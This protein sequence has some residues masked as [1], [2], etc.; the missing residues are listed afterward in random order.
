MPPFGLPID[1]P[2]PGLPPIPGMPGMVDVSLF[3]VDLLGGFFRT[4]RPD[5]ADLPEGTHWLGSDYSNG[6][7]LMYG[8]DGVRQYPWTGEI[9]S[10]IED[11]FPVANWSY[12]YQELLPL[13]GI[14][15]DGACYFIRAHDYEDDVNDPVQWAELLRRVDIK[16]GIDHIANHT[17]RDESGTTKAM[18]EFRGMPWEN[19][20]D[21]MRW[22]AA[23]ANA[24]NVQG[25]LRS[26]EKLL[27]PEW[28][29]VQ[30]AKVM[31]K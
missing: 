1:I 4:H 16:D 14:T 6:V 17:A 13:A 19:M 3:I 5:D 24:H 29:A 22:Y 9:I 15:R 21:Q 7:V 2:I 20:V 27:S 28:Y 10:T 8:H 11:D 31:R 26:W 12:H 30:K 25:G 23:A 18:T